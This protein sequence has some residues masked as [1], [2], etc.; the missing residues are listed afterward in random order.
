MVCL[1]AQN[2]LPTIPCHIHIH[3][4]VCFLKKTMIYCNTLFTVCHTYE[5]FWNI[6][7]CLFDVFFQTQNWIIHNKKVIVRWQFSL[8]IRCDLFRILV[9]TKSLGLHNAI[10][11][12][13]VIAFCR[14]SFM[15]RNS[16][17]FHLENKS[18]KGLIGITL[19]LNLGI[20]VSALIN[21]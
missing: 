21:P 5:F 12:N 4:F 13:K 1:F 3:I 15:V 11:V 19:V 20:S 10:K 16:L 2:D 9:G 8:N 18:M 7:I 17:H 14:K 6:W